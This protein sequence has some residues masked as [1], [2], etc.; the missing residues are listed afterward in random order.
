MSF[1]LLLR[2]AAPMSFDAFL[3]RFSGLSHHIVDEPGKQVY[4]ENRDTGVHFIIDWL[5]PEIEDGPGLNV[6]VN[7]FR[8]RVFGLEAAPLVRRLIEELDC[9]VT[10]DGEAKDPAGYDEAAFLADWSRGNVLA[11]R[12]I[13]AILRQEH[14]GAS[15][16]ELMRRL[17]EE[18]GVLLAPGAEIETVWRWNVKKEE[19][20]EELDLDDAAYFLPSLLW[21]VEDGARMVLA[22]WPPELP[23]M[24]PRAAEKILA[25]LVGP[26]GETEDHALVAIE[27][28][29]AA[30]PGAP[31][32]VGGEP[33]LRYAHGFEELPS[34]FLEA[35]RRNRPPGPLKERL[36]IY[37]PGTV[38]DLDL[39]QAAF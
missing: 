24:L 7:Y 31:A 33:A 10:L 29:L 2:P 34:D 20:S 18:N 15:P 11:H 4:Y 5:G 25:P 17:S 39:L 21:G 19:A 32:V 35:T 27:D 28:L 23:I 30:A 38:R 37:A 26:D 36:A 12:S 9:A 8:P 22:V 14:P 6:N 16:E 3:E 13:A 1:D